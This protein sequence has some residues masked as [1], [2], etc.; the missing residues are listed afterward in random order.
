MNSI[1]ALLSNK[2]FVVDL[3]NGPCPSKNDKSDYTP[4]NPDWINEEASAAV[5]DAF[6]KLLPGKFPFITGIIVE[7][8]PDTICDGACVDANEKRLRYF[9]I[10][11]IPDSKFP[12]NFS[13]PLIHE[14]W[15]VSLHCWE[16]IR[17]TLAACTEE[18]RVVLANNPIPPILNNARLE[19][20]SLYLG[21]Q[22][23]R[24]FS[25]LSEQW[26]E[27]DEFDGLEAD[28]HLYKAR[29]MEPSPLIQKLLD[30][31][32]SDFPEESHEEA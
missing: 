9:I 26:A 5:T 22:P 30:A 21:R 28:I 23:Y 32:D 1:Q 27:D 4:I 3:L 13:Y 25:R 8:N 11:V 24:G 12:Y 15:T 16:I 31:Y 29:E 10:T 18:M 19:W 6:H 2:E 14:M 17:A 20:I 7:M